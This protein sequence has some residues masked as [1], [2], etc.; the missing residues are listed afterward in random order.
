M[1]FQLSL[2]SPSSSAGLP[3]TPS[4]S[5]LF[6]SLFLAPGLEH[7]LQL[8]TYFLWFQ[9][10]KGVPKKPNRWWYVR[11]FLLSPFILLYSGSVILNY[12]EPLKVSSTIS[13]QSWTPSFTLSC[14]KDSA[15]VSLI[16]EEICWIKFTKSNLKLMG[17]GNRT[18]CLQGKGKH[19]LWNFLTEEYFWNI[20]DARRLP[21][22]NTQ[23]ILQMNIMSEL[24]ILAKTVL[25]LL[26]LLGQRARR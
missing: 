18:H 5:C 22:P 10:Q 3:S 17:L 19:S 20:Q 13:T 9:V 15:G 11:I 8:N 2:C 24:M 4:A 1:L 26:T 23:A 21:S 6:L 25:Q 14:R 16:S 12:Y 7:L